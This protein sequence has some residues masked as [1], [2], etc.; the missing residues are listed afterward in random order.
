MKTVKL[1]GLRLQ[2]FAGIK[3]YT[4]SP[5]GESVAVYAA[6]GLGKSSLAAAFLS[7]IGVGNNDPMTK[8]GVVIPGLDCTV[9]G[10]LKVD[11]EKLILS[12]TM[13]EKRNKKTGE[14]TGN[15]YVYAVDNDTVSATVYAEDLEALIAGPDALKAVTD[16]SYLD[17]VNWAALRELVIGIVQD[18]DDD[19]DIAEKV[20]TGAALNDFAYLIKDGRPAA[21]R[22]EKLK[23]QR[24]PLEKRIAAK[25]AEI[26]GAK[27]LLPNEAST[28][29]PVGNYADLQ[30]ELNALIQRKAAFLA[31]DTSSI[32]TQILAIRQEIARAQADYG[33]A[34][35]K[36][37]DERRV[38]YV[39]IE[40]NEREIEGIARLKK[41]YKDSIG[42]HLAR[43]ENLITEW[44][45]INAEVM[46]AEVCNM[47]LAASE[48]PG[49]DADVARLKFN[50]S[51][52]ERIKANTEAGKAN[53][54]QKAEIEEK[55]LSADKRISE[56][57][58]EIG[59]AREAIAGVT[60]PM[61]PDF[62]LKQEA[63]KI[64]EAKMTASTPDT[65]EI[66]EKIAKARQLIAL[67]DEA[68][69]NLK[70]ASDVDKQVQVLRDELKG[71]VTELET[72][73]RGI[74]LLTDF[75]AKK[76]EFLTDAINEKFAPLRFKIV[77]YQAGG[78][79]KDC[80][81]VMA[82]SET[83]GAY[84]PLSKLSRGQMTVAKVEFLNKM[85]EYFEVSA[86]AF[87]DDCDGVTIPLP[88]MEGT[89]YVKLIADVSYQELTVKLIEETK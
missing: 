76:I 78:G 85:Q 47:G 1:M 31:G 36:A 88:L 11:G 69:R 39:A 4:F 82:Y 45:K 66:D 89:Q 52:A 19:L 6:N 79:V 33:D 63:I 5:N 3:D 40:K 12:K 14:L 64:L 80:C 13:R 8:D 62:S 17:S 30:K 46:P 49:Y 58:D 15:E 60:V 55:W 43:R 74:A 77:N 10:V 56:L 53:N 84:V 44:H 32:G 71:S 37:G 26:K 9:S 75:V 70:T 42:N 83:T 20:F 24:A 2:N 72:V 23:E 22:L 18:G 73:E 35:R 7:L 27:L 67:H 65:T 54:E 61:E 48:H 21:Y 57:E 34:E 51:R 68:A 59:L 38:F 81:E 87:I 16:T 25:N 28:I 86:P 50:S 29:P 41:E